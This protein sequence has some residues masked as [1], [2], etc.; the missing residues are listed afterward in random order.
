MALNS[1]AASVVAGTLSDGSAIA[2]KP[3]L[4]FVPR[5]H[6]CAEAAQRGYPLLGETTLDRVIRAPKTFDSALAGFVEET[7][8]I[9]NEGRQHMSAPRIRVDEHPVRGAFTATRVGL[10]ACVLA[11]ALALVHVHGARADLA[12]PSLTVGSITIEDG[13]A[14]V[15]GAVDDVNALL[16][17]NGALVDID[18][19]GNFLAV[20]DLDADVLVLSLAEHL[21]ETTTIRI[22]VDVLVENGGEGVLNDLIDAGVTV[23]VP[24]D[25]FEVID[26][27]GPILSGNIVNADLLHSA[28]VNGINILNRVGP[29]GGFSFALPWPSS[30]SQQVTMVVVDRRG[31]SQ[32]TTFRTTRISSTFRTRAGTSV[33]SAGARG[34]VIVKVRFDKSTLR[35][36][37]KLG[38]AVTVKDRRGLLIRGAALRL[39]GMP[40]RYLATEP[41]ARASRTGSGRRHSRFA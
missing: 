16:E 7:S 1:L 29:N 5:V 13:T 8:P 12:A 36:N 19:A 9:P 15:T 38:V 18:D 35:W 20:V 33:S 26:D 22:P 41:S 32:T 39:A 11:I 14:V 30:P 25:G 6:T 21:G 4:S 3:V 23:D 34:V 37:R 10:A 40:S 31:V 28:A 17:I 27:N 2:V 24:V